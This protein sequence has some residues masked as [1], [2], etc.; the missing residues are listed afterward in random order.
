M[1]T[2]AESARA[3]GPRFFQEQDRLRGGPAPEL[4]TP[5]YQAQI[6][7]FPHMDRAGHE[8]FAVGFYAGIPDAMHTI[9]EVVAADDQV[10]VRFTIN[11]TH[12]ATFMGIPASGRRV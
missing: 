8:G 11:G 5:D 10:A 3:L 12:T 1:T 2:T 4:C 7:S 9:D 6:G